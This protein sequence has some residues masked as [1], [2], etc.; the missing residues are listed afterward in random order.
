MEGYFDHLFLEPARHLVGRAVALYNRDKASALAEFSNPQG[1]FV[2]GEHYVY[3]LDSTGVVLAHGANPDFVGEDFYRVTDSDGKQFIQEIVESADQKG[4]GYVEYRWPDPVTKA[5]RPKTVFFVKTDRAIICSGVYG[6]HPAS[7]I[8][9]EGADQDYCPP[10]SPDPA[11][12][13]FKNMRAVDPSPELIA[14]DAKRMVEKATAFY[15]VNDSEVALAEFSNRNGRYVKGEQYVFVLDTTGRMLAHGVDKDY[16]GKD[17][18]RKMDSDGRRFIK[19]IVDKANELGSGWVE[20]KW[21]N[22]VTKREELK[23]VYFKKAN[24]VI[25]CSGIYNWNVS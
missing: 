21:F 8:P 11:I 7:C 17:F 16:I 19:D 9:E 25:I 18:Y 3:A 2:D 14:D 13:P 22:P 15:M 12:E 4:S 10:A 5:E 20:Y 1:D 6:A 23:T 24:G